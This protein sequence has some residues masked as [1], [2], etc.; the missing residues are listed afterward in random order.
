MACVSHWEQDAAYNYIEVPTTLAIKNKILA[1]DLASYPTEY[2]PRA[3]INPGSFV[4]ALS[5][6]PIR[7]DNAAPVESEKCAHQAEIVHELH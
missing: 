3:I 6:K 7:D 4:G 1:R 2:Q 5:E